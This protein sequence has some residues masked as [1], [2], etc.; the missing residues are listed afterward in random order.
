MPPVSAPCGKAGVEITSRART[1]P[2]NKP[3]AFRLATVILQQPRFICPKEATPPIPNGRDSASVMGRCQCK[4]LDETS[5]WGH[6]R[7]KGE[8]ILCRIR[9]AVQWFKDE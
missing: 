7:E 6:S 2:A 3:I 1:A 5:Y 9:R 8:Q 4:I